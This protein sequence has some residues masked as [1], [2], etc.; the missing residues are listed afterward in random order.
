MVDND[1]GL[2]LSVGYL[3]K[4]MAGVYGN[5]LQVCT[6]YSFDDKKGGY[7]SPVLRDLSITVEEVSGISSAETEFK[8]RDSNVLRGGSS[9]LKQLVPKWGKPLV[10]ETAKFAAGNVNPIFGIFLNAAFAQVGGS[11][12]IGKTARK[13]IT[14][15][16][17][18]KWSV[19]K[20]RR[21]PGSFSINLE[22]A[23]LLA[24][25]STNMNTSGSVVYRLKVRAT[26]G[27][28]I[29]QSKLGDALQKT[30][31]ISDQVRFKIDWQ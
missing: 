1:V 26:T 24:L 22:T 18:R 27:K 15:K 21:S 23:L 12:H 30:G 4:P 29:R 13:K 7:Y 31:T 3:N 14:A 8:I 19:K 9:R 17:E 28:Q 20:W 10:I 11:G 2:A 5:H 25:Q 16:E 6:I